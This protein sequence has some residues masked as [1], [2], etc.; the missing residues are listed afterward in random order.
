M[1]IDKFSKEI[2][3]PR[4]SVQKIAAS[5]NY[6]YKHYTIPKRSG[7]ERDIYHPTPRLK[8]VQRWITR[9]VIR[10][11]PVSDAAMAY[12]KGKSITD[13]ARLHAG[14]R[15]LLKM[16]FTDFF[17]SIKARDLQPILTSRGY[18]PEDVNFILTICFKSGSLTIGAPSSPAVSNIVMFALDQE[19]KGIAD[20][21]KLTYS[22][23][24]DDL[25]F[26]GNVR[27]NLIE[28]KKDVERLIGTWASPNLTLNQRKT[29]LVSSAHRQKVTGITLTTDGE[30]SIGREKKRELRAIVHRS[31]YQKLEPEVEAYVQGWLAYANSIEPKF[32]DSLRKKFDT[33]LD[34]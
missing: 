33:Y 6:L 20:R 32:V 18:D 15:F 13:N 29:V 22:R 4:P 19:F 24:A 16:D 17:P 27:G 31:T 2:G 9:H 28:A 23:Y 25:T 14:K 12:R 5:A 10:D 11:L 34:F 1:L 30:I 7:G 26:A 3:L 21:R 8:L